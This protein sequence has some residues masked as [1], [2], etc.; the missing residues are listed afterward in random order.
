MRK[1]VRQ[2]TIAGLMLAVLMATRVP[3]QRIPGVIDV[4][5]FAEAALVAFGQ[6]VGDQLRVLATGDYNADGLSDILLGSFNADGPDNQRLNSGSAYIILG[7]PTGLGLRDLGN[8]DDLREDVVFFGAEENDRFGVSATSGEV[9]GDGVAD[10]IIG[11]PGADGPGNS[12]ANA[13]EVYIFFGGPDLMT[14]TIRDVAE[15]R[16]RG[17]DI[18]IFGEEGFGAFGDTLGASVALGDVNGDGL[19]DLIIGAP[20]TFGPGNIRAAAGSVYIIFGGPRLSTRGV[21]DLADPLAGA[22]VVI[23]GA[24]PVDNAGTVVKAGDL[25]GD[26]IDDVVFSAP[27]A[28]GPANLRRDA[29]EVYVLFGR[30]DLATPSVRD[31]AGIFAPRVDLTIFGED[32][33]DGLGGSL[34]IGDVSGDQ[35]NDLIIGAVNPLAPAGA[36]GPDNS[37]LNTGELYLIVG[38]RALQFEGSRDMAGQFGRPTDQTIFGADGADQFGASLSLS[39]LNGDGLA[40]LIVGAPGADGP[41]NE[42]VNAGEV[43]VMFGGLNLFNGLRRDIAGQVGWSADL[44]L[45]GPAAGQNFGATL[46]VADMDGDGVDDLIVGAPLAGGPENV[47]ANAGGAFVISGGS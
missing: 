27:T 11:A 31:L 5:E 18:T 22:D 16:G 43:Y 44:T 14:G 32:P 37:R 3:G 10:I 39:D 17:P 8:R 30:Q 6:N 42:R 12:R 38:H 25:N 15:Q 21:I 24:D 33:G 35:V 40:D 4:A 47:R 29:G 13:G 19:T 20:G 1:L 9:N 41:N 2:C 7:N 36:D 28:D 46:A 23:H 26:G 45:V 34:L